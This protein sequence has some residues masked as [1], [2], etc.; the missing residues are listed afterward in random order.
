MLKRTCQTGVP[1]AQRLL[2]ALIFK[3]KM[4]IK[5]FIL[6]YIKYINKI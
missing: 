2:I 4:F 1:D 6:H 3:L 5:V